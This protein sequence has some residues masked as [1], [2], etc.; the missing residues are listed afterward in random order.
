MNYWLV[1]TEPETFSWDM[2]ESEKN[3]MWDG[4]RNYQAR[5]NLRKMKMGDT[6]F[7]YHSGKNPGIVGIAEVVK[8]H[9]PDPTAKEGDWSVVNLKPV[10]KLKQIITLQ[11]IKKNQKLQNM[12]LIRSSRLSVQPVQP[13][14]YNLIMELWKY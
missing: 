9:Y 12:Y 3:S 10:R 14:E 13:E 6:L 4:V 1:K 5:N 7:F 8:E 11:E 2:L